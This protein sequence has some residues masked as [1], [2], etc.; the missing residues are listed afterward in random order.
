[1]AQF[2]KNNIKKEIARNSVFGNI[3][4][5]RVTSTTNWDCGDILVFDT[6]TK[7]VRALAAEADAASLLGV[8]IQG[9]RNGLAVGPYTG[10]TDNA[11]STQPGSLAG[12]LY[13]VEAEFLVKA[14]DTLVFGDAV[15][16]FDAKTISSAGTKQIGIY[17]G[18][19]TITS[20]VAGQL[21]TIRMGSRYPADTLKI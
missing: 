14:G 10:L 18:S 8:S 6:T 5:S 7:K 16:A 13:G 19:A 12:A 17:V 21:A 20:A 9:I 11:G 4:G 15:F 1:M 3:G 2:G